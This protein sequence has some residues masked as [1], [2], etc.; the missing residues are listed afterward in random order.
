MS[1]FLNL[2]PP[3]RR[4]R[5]HKIRLMV[6]PVYEAKS[7]ELDE[8]RSKLFKWSLESLVGKHLLF[9]LIVWV[10]LI[11]FM[12]IWK[13]NMLFLLILP[14]AFIISGILVSVPIYFTFRKELKIDD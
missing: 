11:M 12:F 8:F 13:A 10:P 2:I 9:Q 7:K 3:I 14:A 4:H 6:D 5:L 1:N